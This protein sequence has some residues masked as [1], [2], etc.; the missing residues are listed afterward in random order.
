MDPRVMAVFQAFFPVLARAQSGGID[1]EDVK[2][3]A[4]EVFASFPAEDVAAFRTA[5][6]DSARV[7]FP[8]IFPGKSAAEIE[9]MLE[10][11]ADLLGF[12]RVVN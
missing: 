3:E 12:P 9:V 4:A 10:K 7:T 5:F 8:I 2:A 11:A 6:L 1:F